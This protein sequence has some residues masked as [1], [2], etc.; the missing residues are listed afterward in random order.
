MKSPCFV[1]AIKIYEHQIDLE[2]NAADFVLSD[3]HSDPTTTTTTAGK[4]RRRS[5]RSEKNGTGENILENSAIGFMSQ[6]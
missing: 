1:V 4:R 3:T 6:N 5:R 2:V